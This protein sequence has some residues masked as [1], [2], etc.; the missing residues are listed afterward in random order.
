VPPVLA[1]V[2]LLHAPLT[3]GAASEM[4]EKRMFE[5]L[6]RPLCLPRGK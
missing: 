2:S 3:K 5:I 4:I 6:M 1:G